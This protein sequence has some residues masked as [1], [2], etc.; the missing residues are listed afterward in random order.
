MTLIPDS[1]ESREEYKARRSYDLMTAMIKK[2][3]FGYMPGMDLNFYI[4]PPSH[5]SAPK[6][7][8]DGNPVIDVEFKI[9]ARE[10]KYLFTLDDDGNA[11]RLALPAPKP[12]TE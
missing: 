7:S 10:S 12:E 11:D 1:S 3:M 8:P 9:V 6:P 4:S 5:G 2:A